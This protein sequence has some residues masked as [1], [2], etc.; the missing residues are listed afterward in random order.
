MSDCPVS[1]LKEVG[2]AWLRQRWPQSLI[3]PEFSAS[4]GGGAR[5]D[6]AAVTD[7]ELIGLEL[8]GDGDSAGRLVIQ[9]VQYS[10][11]A[12]RMYLL[13][14]PSLHKS[15]ANKKP[16]DWF[17]MKY[18]DGAVRVAEYEPADGNLMPTSPLRLLEMCHADE[19]RGLARLLKVDVLGARGYTDVAR[20]ISESAPLVDIRREVLRTLRHRAW[21]KLMIPKTVYHPEVA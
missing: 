8:K 18:E 15:C 6:L 3:I 20:R 17:M 10:A 12:S 1:V 21:H 4:Q 2:M 14:S 7:T 5:I 9:G 19:V 16:R 13:P 11:V